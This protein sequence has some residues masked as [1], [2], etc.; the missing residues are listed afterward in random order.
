M[1]EG[2]DYGMIVLCYHKINNRVN[3]WNHITVTPDTFMK[4]ME[5][6]MNHYDVVTTA[7]A[8]ESEHTVSISFDDGYE[9]S[10]TN[11]LP[12]LEKLRIPA[13]FFISTQRLGSDEE[14]WCNE[15]SRRIMRGG[16]EKTKIEIGEEKIS[17]LSVEDRKKA[18]IQIFNYLKGLDNERRD[19]W[20]HFI[21]EW[22]GASSDEPRKEFRM[23]GFEQLKLLSESEL[24]TIGAHTVNHPSLACLDYNDQEYEIK[25]SINAIKKITGKA[26]EQFAYPFGGTRDYNQDTFQILKQNGILRAFSTWNKRILSDI[27]YEI[28]RICVT[29]CSM[30]NFIYKIKHPFSC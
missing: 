23:L 30:Q 21:R 26:V 3:D 17:T 9:D 13:T 29:E 25:N 10:V 14:D 7:Y 19:D 5:F 8:Y 27:N 11:I 15:L 1:R 24:V 12:L 6:V 2:K 28:P 16:Q 18:N 4:Q 22:A 20:M